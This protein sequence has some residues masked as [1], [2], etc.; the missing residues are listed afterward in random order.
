MIFFMAL[1][2]V[3]SLRMC[4]THH[5][6]RGVLLWFQLILF[7]LLGFFAFNF[8]VYFYVNFLFYKWVSRRF[9]NNCFE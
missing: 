5:I 6:Y 4:S 3:S 9:L 1:D 7:I 8:A 2:F